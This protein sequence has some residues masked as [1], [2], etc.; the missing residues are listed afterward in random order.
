VLPIW[1]NGPSTSP[2]QWYYCAMHAIPPCPATVM[3]MDLSALRHHHHP[4]SL[5]MFCV[6]YCTV[7]QC[8]LPL[9]LYAHV[10]IVECFHNNSGSFP[11]PL[12]LINCIDTTITSASTTPYPSACIAQFEGL[13]LLVVCL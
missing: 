1:H 7:L 12:L 11:M 13:A 6:L 4:S 5:C 8:L 9:F 3:T 10:P 2:S